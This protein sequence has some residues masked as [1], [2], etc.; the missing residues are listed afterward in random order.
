MMFPSICFFFTSFNRFSVP[1]NLDMATSLARAALHVFAD[2]RDVWK[3]EREDRMCAEGAR[4]RRAQAVIQ[5][6][7]MDCYA[8]RRLCTSD[9]PPCGALDRMNA[10]KVAARADSNLKAGDLFRR[11]ADD[12]A[13]LVASEAAAYA[14]MRA[15]ICAEKRKAR[16]SELYQQRKPAR[17]VERGENV[18]VAQ[19]ETAEALKRETDAARVLKRKIRRAE[20]Y[21]ERKRAR[22]EAWEAAAFH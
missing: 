10:I 3:Q 22:R 19:R 5:R 6:G 11:E 4:F 17:L 20:L 13:R 9:P 16:R 1:W 15:E 21:Q 14:E 8:I 12:R 7:R 18:D 2:H